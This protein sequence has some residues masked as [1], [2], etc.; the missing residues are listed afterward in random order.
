M[1]NI[2]KNIANIK[3]EQQAKLDKKNLKRIPL[4]IVWSVSQLLVA[5]MVKLMADK[6]Q[7][8]AGVEKKAIVL[9]AIEK[10]YD[11]SFTIF[12]IPFVPNF[13]E[14]IIHSRVKQILMI[15]VSA[16]IDATV[17]TFRETGVIAK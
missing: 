7:D 10:F 14:P 16:T 13:I 8:L 9:T 5:K 2:N 11:T 6:A 12:D 3:T 4:Q 17:T 15:L 1:E